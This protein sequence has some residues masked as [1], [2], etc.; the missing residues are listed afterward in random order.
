M[1]GGGEANT[2]CEKWFNVVSDCRGF[3]GKK[4]GKKRRKKR[5][6]VGGGEKKVE[7]R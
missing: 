3:G 5:K 7:R 4:E 1:V 6:E 2:W